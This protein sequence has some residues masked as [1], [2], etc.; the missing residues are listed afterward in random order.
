MKRMIDNKDYEALKNDVNVLNEKVDNI[1]TIH[2]I[3]IDAEQMLSLDTAQLT[4][5]QFDILD[6]NNIVSVNLPTGDNLIFTKMA[7]TE[8]VVTYT[9]GVDYDVDTMATNYFIVETVR[10]TKIATILGNTIS[11]AEKLYQ[12]NIE[13]SNSDDGG[14]ILI[15]IINN[16]PDAMTYVDLNT[17]LTSNGFTYSNTSHMHNFYP[18]AIG[19]SGT[20]T[21]IGIAYYNVTTLYLRKPA[22][23]GYSTTSISFSNIND[24]VV[25]L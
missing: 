25:P 3:T 16:I 19:V 13:L 24:V 15:S 4:E 8:V 11:K 7:D 22:S 1:K 23:A 6:S 20:N 2:T 12:H 18:N 9:S 5:E 14:T 10:S 21:L 17:F